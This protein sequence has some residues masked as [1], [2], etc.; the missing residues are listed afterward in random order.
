MTEQLE[1][2]HRYS[3]S[4]FEGWFNCPG[5]IAMESG[6]PDEYSPWAD[7]GSAA[8]FIF[9][10]CQD[11]NCQPEEYAEREVICWEK[12]GERDGQ[13]FAGEPLPEGAKER[14]RWIVDDE[15]VANLNTALNVL[16]MDLKPGR[17][18]LTE[19]RVHFGDAIGVKGAFGTTDVSIIEDGG[20]DIWVKDLK[21][22][23]KPVDATLNG[24]GMLYALGVLEDY[25]L[26]YDLSNVKRVWIQ[27]LQPR[28]NNAST[29]CT[30]PEAL[31]EF[32]EKAKEAIEL[33][34]EA[35]FTANVP[36][37]WFETQEEWQKLYLK[38]SE[39]GCTWCKAKGRCPKFAADN[40]QTIVAALPATIDDLEDLDAPLGEPLTG[41]TALALPKAKFEITLQT[42]IANV[43][44]LDLDTVAK[45]YA[46]SALFDEFRDAV[47][48]RLHSGLMAGA[49]HPDWKLVQGRAGNRAWRSPE[50]AEEV[51]KSM[52]LKVDEMYAKKVISPSAADKLLAKN[53][54]RKWKRVEELIVRP[55]G[56]ITIAHASDKRE[57][58][59]PTGMLPDLS[60]DVEVLVD[61]AAEKDASVVSKVAVI[62]G[63][64]T[65]LATKTIPA[66]EPEILQQY[67]QDI[68]DLV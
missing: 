18:L 36:N 64:A 39:K 24:Q 44:S 59:Q 19:K 7:E 23:R 53:F 45:L 43:P 50:E 15:M 40:V 49:Q 32:A 16:K 33:S 20:E 57:A 2:H 14:S 68:L 28:I 1:Q 55:E 25:G 3:A 22:G 47:A 41:E 30:T 10:L 21:Y 5:K 26:V 27:I 46:A 54:P 48:K 52:R 38:T 13:C 61:S 11:N 42:A 56:K 31:Y 58:Y 17:E 34:E 60:D 29:W 66:E 6:I 4:G 63:K 8:H 51:M 35:L 9:A 65:V 12:P 62:E 67:D 37:Q